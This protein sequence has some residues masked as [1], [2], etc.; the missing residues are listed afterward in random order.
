[1]FSVFMSISYFFSFLPRFVTDRE[2][3]SD[4]DVH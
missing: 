2:Q 3:P 1:L 4:N